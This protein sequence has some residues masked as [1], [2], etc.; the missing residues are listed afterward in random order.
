V[1][2]LHLLIEMKQFLSGIFETE[3]PEH[4]VEGGE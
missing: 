1:T 4:R 2:G 3:A